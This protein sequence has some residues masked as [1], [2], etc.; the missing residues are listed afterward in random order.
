MPA[1]SERTACWTSPFDAFWLAVFDTLNGFMKIFWNASW[2]PD[3]AVLTNK[4]M[5]PPL[6]PGTLPQSRVWP[7]KI[8]CTCSCDRFGTGFALFVIRQMPSC[9][10]LLNTSPPGSPGFGSRDEL[11]IVT[12]PRETSEMPTSE[13]PWSSLNCTQ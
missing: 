2:V 13:P 11:P 5:P 6:A 3:A 1:L 12:R 10:I 7:E 9:A 8:D 4:S